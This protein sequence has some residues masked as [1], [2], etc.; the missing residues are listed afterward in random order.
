MSKG[1]RCIPEQIPEGQAWDTLL[2]DYPE[3]TREDI[4]TV[5]FYARSCLDH[6]EIIA[7]GA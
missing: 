7:V 3:L 6:S 1:L 4:Q 5:L 2:G